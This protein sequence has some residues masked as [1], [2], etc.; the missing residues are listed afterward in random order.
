[1]RT[2]WLWI[3]GLLCVIVVAAPVRAEQPATDADPVAAIAAAIE[4]AE[5]DAAWEAQIDVVVSRRHGDQHS[6]HRES[7]HA[8]FERS[9]T[10]YARHLWADV[11]REGAAPPAAG[12]P[13]RDSHRRPAGR[14][15]L[16]VG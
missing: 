3:V 6:E 8:E 12:S 7:W 15:V 14:V 5:R 1:M 13:V 9:P 2:A 10:R 4:A 11:P 16:Q